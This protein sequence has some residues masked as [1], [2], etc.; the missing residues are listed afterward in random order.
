ME[1]HKSWKNNHDA[2]SLKRF[3]KWNEIIGSMKKFEFLSQTE[4]ITNL[5]F[6]QIFVTN[7]IFITSLNEFLLNFHEED[8]KLKR[9]NATV[10]EEFL[11]NNIWEKTWNKCY[12]TLKLIQELMLNK[13]DSV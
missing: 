11:C 2:V 6:P 10:S 1:C 3:T 12:E 13:Q 7:W 4:V 5:N 8:S 9:R